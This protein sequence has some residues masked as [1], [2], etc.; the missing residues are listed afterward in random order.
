MQI[1]LY[2]EYRFEAAHRLPRLPEGHK[3]FR[4]HGHSFK[5][6]VKLV[7]PVNP[8]TGFLIDFGD[9]DEI[10]KPVVDQLDHYYLN[11]IAGL[12]NPTSEVFCGWLWQRLK[13]GLPM[14]AAV[15]V[16]ETCDARCTYRGP[17]EK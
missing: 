10:V 12:E 14:L 5:F 16:A 8:E 3:C 1:E 7:G 2:R 4:L 17:G 13:P 15:T 9:V 11:D 6:E